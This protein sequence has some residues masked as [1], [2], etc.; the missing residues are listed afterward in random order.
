VSRVV[1][2]GHHAGT[3]YVTKCGYRNDDFTPYVFK[4]TDYGQTWQ[5]IS[6]NLPPYP[7]NVIFEDQKN[8]DLLFIGND[9]GVYVS[10]NGGENWA[11]LKANM[12]PVVVRDLLVHPREN[13]LVVGTY[14]RAAWITDI[15]P[16]QQLDRAVQ[17]ADFHLFDVEPKPQMNFSQQAFWGN[18][19]MTGSNHWN[20]SNEPNGL[21]I[22][23]YFKEPSG[24]PAEILI[25]DK[26]GQTVH[27]DTLE[28]RPGI[29]KTYW[30]TSRAAPGDYEVVLN[31][32]GQSIRKQGVVKQRWLWPVLNYR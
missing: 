13:D 24:S 17:N 29:H 4:T 16:L 9:H 5:D 12:P 8:E 21:E 26:K 31:W 20:V 32:N 3:A 1:T 2:S 30:N 25:Q 15:S 11:A 7:V 14:G 23:Y 22:W 19:H 6:S 27:S 10:L 28:V 18:Y